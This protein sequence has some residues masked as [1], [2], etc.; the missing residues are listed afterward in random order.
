MLVNECRRV[1]GVWGAPVTG[2]DY[3]RATNPQVVD[4]AI[5]AFDRIIARHEQVGRDLAELQARIER[6]LAETGNPVSQSTG[7]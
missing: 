7:D 5:A 3:L 1:G 4:D 6:R 2:L